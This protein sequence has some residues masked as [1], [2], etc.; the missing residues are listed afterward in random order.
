MLSTQEKVMADY[1]VVSL[2]E[3]DI[4][5][6]KLRI[7]IDTNK[8]KLKELFADKLGKP[9]EWVADNSKWTCYALVFE[10]LWYPAQPLSLTFKDNN[11]TLVNFNDPRRK[12]ANWD[13]EIELENYAHIKRDL[14]QYLGKESISNESSSQD[15]SATWDYSKL[16]MYLAC[17]SK[18]GGCGLGIGPKNL[19]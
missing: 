17:D 9:R 1:S 16:S 5:F 3:G 12:M 18:T 2:V 19:Q 4:P 8:A 6:G 10:I 14:V 15:M 13:Y 11:L 7:P